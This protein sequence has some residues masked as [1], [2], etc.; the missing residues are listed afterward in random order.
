MRAARPADA[1]AIAAIHNQGIEDRIATFETRLKDPGAVSDAIAH[2]LCCLVYER[3][4]EV[5][6]FAKAAPYEDRSHYYDGVGEAT[7]YVAREHRGA[8]AG[9]ALLAALAEAA[10]ARDLH[11][12]TAKVFAGNGASLKLFAGA[13]FRTVGTHLRHG[14]LD[15]EWLDVVVLERSLD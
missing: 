2:W 1:E 14:Q 6:G 10:R 8:G 5:I 15:G 4:G 12:L 13:G 7:V 3:A 11:K 9:A